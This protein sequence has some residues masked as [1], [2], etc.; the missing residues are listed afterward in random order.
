[1]NTSYNIDLKFLLV[2]QTKQSPLVCVAKAYFLPCAPVSVGM[3]TSCSWAI[4][5][6][7]GYVHITLH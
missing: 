2:T 4:I 3:S 5:V 1:M 6:I 7:C